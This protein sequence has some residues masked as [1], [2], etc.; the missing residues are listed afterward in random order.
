[1]EVMCECVRQP[2]DCTQ[3]EWYED[4]LSGPVTVPMVSTN[5]SPPIA[6]PVQVPP[7]HVVQQ[8]VDENGALRHVILSP[9]PPMVPMPPHYN[10]ANVT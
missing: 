5:S 6:M 7:G 4:D 1:M 8:I 2:C 9:Q 3:I 10:V